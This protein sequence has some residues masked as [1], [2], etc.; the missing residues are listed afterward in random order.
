LVPTIVMVLPPAV[1][2]LAAPLADVCPRLL[3]TAVIVGLLY[4]TING[5]TA[6]CPLTLME[7]GICVP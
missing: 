1:G 5:V 3:Y 6:S 7:I 4:E 2:P